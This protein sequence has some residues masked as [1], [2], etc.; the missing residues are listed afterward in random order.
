MFEILGNRSEYAVTSVEKTRGGILDG[1]II[2]FL[3]SSVTEGSG[4]CGESFVDYLEHK[5]GVVAVKEA[6]SGTTLV[7][8]DETSYIPRMKKIDT[9]IKADAFV[10]QL[11][12][13]DA[14]KGFPLGTLSDSFH[15]NEFDTSTIAGSIEYI[16]SYA[17]DTWKCPV[18]FY[19]GTKFD[20][21]AYGNMV[22]L[23]LKI[24]EKW[25][26]GV[27]DLWNDNELNNISE[28]QRN[29]YMND[30]IHPTKAGYLK[31]WL[32]KIE[33]SLE[34]LMKNGSSKLSDY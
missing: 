32:P 12:T 20:N 13:N 23:L 16:I 17:M 30:G 8:M 4:S 14:S 5:D 15:R 11:S 18:I 3:G 6:I 1:K 19:T 28:K 7:T 26:C 33:K 24:Q 22:A 10:C 9:S 34:N 31:W 2:I 29:L 25:D 27:I 21:E